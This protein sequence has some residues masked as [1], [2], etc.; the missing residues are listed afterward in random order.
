[1]PPAHVGIFGNHDGLPVR[2]QVCRER[3]RQDLIETVVSLLQ[4][5]RVQ[6]T[7]FGDVLWFRGSGG[8]KGSGRQFTQA[9]QAEERAEVGKHHRDQQ[10]GRSESRLSAGF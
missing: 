5:R 10:S 1:M 8:L 7:S 4:E 3:V 9:Q 2:Y 6:K